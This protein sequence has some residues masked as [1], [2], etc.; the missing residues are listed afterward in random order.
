MSKK[1]KQL[2]TRFAIHE[3]NNQSRVAHLSALQ[4]W[5]LL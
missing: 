2:S 5:C 1:R 3:V 4:N